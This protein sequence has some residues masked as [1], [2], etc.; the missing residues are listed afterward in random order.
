MSIPNKKSLILDLLD[1]PNGQLVAESFKE[2]LFRSGDLGKAAKAASDEAERLG[3]S[4]GFLLAFFV[5]L[6]N[7]GGPIASAV[8]QELLRKKPKPKR[9]SN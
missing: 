1:T 9:K 6:I 2:E 8:I 4:N 3:V 5:D 7:L